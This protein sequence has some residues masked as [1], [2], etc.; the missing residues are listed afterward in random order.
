MSLLIIIRT[1][2]EYQRNI[3]VGRYNDFINNDNNNHNLQEK[4]AQEK[5]ALELGLK[6]PPEKK[7]E[8]NTRLFEAENS[9][10]F[11]HKNRYLLPCGFE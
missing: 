11:K 6:S 8:E 9:H 7:K 3:G 4:E 2:K 1:R 10:V 5:L